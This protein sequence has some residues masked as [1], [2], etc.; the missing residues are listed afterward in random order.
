MNR[1]TRSSRSHAQTR[2]AGS[3]CTQP[4]VAGRPP[5]AQKCERG[6][7]HTNAPVV[8]MSW[9]LPQIMIGAKEAAVGDRNAKPL[10]LK[11]LSAVRL[12]PAK[13]YN[14]YSHLKPNPLFLHRVAPRGVQER[15][16]AQRLSDGAVGLSAAPIRTE[17]RL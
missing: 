13:F 12:F 4:V 14:C 1:V 7:K 16:G 10:A 5:L 15:D 6:A 11:P 9:A 8:T 2:L 17:T 3:P